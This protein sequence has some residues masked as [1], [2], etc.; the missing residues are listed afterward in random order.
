MTLGQPVTGQLGTLY[1]GGVIV[2]IVGLGDTPR[3]YTVLLPC[4]EAIE[5]ETVAAR[6]GQT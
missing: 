6:I 5:T 1:F 2:M 4:G 3:R